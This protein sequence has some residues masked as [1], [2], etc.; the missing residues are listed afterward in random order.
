MLPAMGRLA[1][2]DATALADVLAVQC[3][4]VS[5]RQALDCA[6]TEPALRHRIRQ[7]GPWQTILPGVYLS[8]SGVVTG[9]QRAIA[10]YLYAGKPIAITGSAALAFH[11]MTGA[12]SDVVDVLVPLGCR[13]ADA[14][15]ARMHRTGVVPEPRYPDCG[16]WYAPPARSVADAVRQLSGISDVRAVVAGAVQRGKVAVWQLAQELELGPVNGSARLRAALAEVADGVRS[17][18]EA[19]LRSLIKR[20]RLPMPIFNAQ[21]SVGGELLAIPDAWWPEAGVA[22]EVDSR[23]W[24]FS[25]RDWEETLARHARMTAQGILVLHIPPRRVRVA[26]KEVAGEIRAALASSHGRRLSHIVTRPA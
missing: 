11:S 2:F 1:Q 3:G 4:V 17:S 21:L 16:V 14:G 6:M 19:D 20:E 22:V 23:E 18:A 26:G 24:H 13:R 15:F 25:P 5:R 10:A 12:R 9:K 8:N 7:D